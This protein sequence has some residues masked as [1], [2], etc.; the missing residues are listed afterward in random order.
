MTFGNGLTD[1]ENTRV[2]VL[3]GNVLVRPDHT[4]IGIDA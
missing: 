1:V 3:Y 4:V 2:D